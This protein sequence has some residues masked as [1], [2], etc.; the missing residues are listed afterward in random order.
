M[1]GGVISGNTVTGGDP[2]GGG[3]SLTRGGT[4]TMEGG[5]IYGQA[6]RLPA[7]T[8]ASRAN[9]A[10]RAGSLYYDL[11]SM[12]RWGMGGTYTKGGE[13]QTGGAEIRGTDD[14]LIA[15]PPK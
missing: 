14:T 9:S 10:Q 4:F 12:A 3:V 15:L 11:I 6:G 2:W 7:G 8:D 1:Q 13:S 5:T